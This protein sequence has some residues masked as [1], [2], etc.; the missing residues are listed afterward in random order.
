MTAAPTRNRSS[1]PTAG[2]PPARRPSGARG[3]TRGNLAPHE[4]VVDLLLVRRRID[5]V[6]ASLEAEGYRGQAV[7]LEHV[8]ELVSSAIARL[9]ARP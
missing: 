4:L 7:A 2:K 1:R 5:G 9:E 3:F 6:E 8:R